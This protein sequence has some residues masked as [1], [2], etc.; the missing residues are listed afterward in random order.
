MFSVRFR[1]R[2]WGLS[3]YLEA[4]HIRALSQASFRIWR[5]VN[6]NSFALQYAIDKS[7]RLKQNVYC[8]FVHLTAAFDRVPRHRLWQRMQQCGLHGR[9]LEAIKSLYNGALIAWAILEARP[10][11]SKRVARSVPLYLVSSSTPSRASCCHKLLKLVS[12]FGALCEA[13]SARPRASFDLF[14]RSS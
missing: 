8:C 12:P 4:Q 11:D 13:A 10:A 5:S 2:L 7:R 14:R 1:L 9:M 3:S 6:Y